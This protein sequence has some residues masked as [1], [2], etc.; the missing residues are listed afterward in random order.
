MNRYDRVIVWRI[1]QKCNMNCLFCSCSNDVERKRDI[2]D[3]ANIIRMLRLLGQYS[4]QTGKKILID[5]IGGEP[6][7]YDGIFPIS[8]EARKTGLFVST[9]TNGLLLNTKERR[10]GV[11]KNFSEIVF[12]MDGFAFC[13]DR[14][15]KYDGYFEAVNKAIADIV[16]EKNARG[17]NLSVK[18]NTILLRED[19]DSFEPFCEYLAG[20]GVDGLTFNQLGGYDRP[21][22]YQNNRLLSEQV[23]RF[24][25]RLP[26]V[27]AKC[28]DMGLVI[29][30][31]GDY[32]DRII[33]STGNE[34][35]P[36]SDCK[37]GSWFW[38]INENAFVSPCSYTTYEYMLPLETIRTTSDIED[39]EARFRVMRET[40]RSCWCNDC[41]CT[42]NYSKFE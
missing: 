18:V 20:L 5:W 30:G 2:A 7:L 36:I 41:H 1:T 6:F 15:R 33:A 4:A 12:S 3:K 27:R 8:E 26:D 21:E 29:R 39:M 14:I 9:T 31:G 37:P 11:I 10:D 23:Q 22:F 34:K 16:R 35:I 24:A 28:S 19:I 25:Q 17:V 42:Q 38:F 13:S 32:L 40:R